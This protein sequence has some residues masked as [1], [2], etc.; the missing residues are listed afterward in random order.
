V[1]YRQ[2]DRPFHRELEAPVPEPIGQHPVQAE[3]PLQPAEDQVRPDLSAGTG[4]QIPL[5]R[6]LQHLHPAGKAAQGGEQGI[7]AAA[8]QPS[9]RPKVASPP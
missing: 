6:A 5:A 2:I 1:E 8:G 7:D 4:F 9:T 3:F